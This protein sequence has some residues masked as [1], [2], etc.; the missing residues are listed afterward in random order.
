MTTVKG[1]VILTSGLNIIN[2]VIKA[3]FL[4]LLL[5]YNAYNLD[6]GMSTV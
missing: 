2:F 6:T 5:Y 3:W 1:Q 4:C